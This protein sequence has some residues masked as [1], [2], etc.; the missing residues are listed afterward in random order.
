MGTSFRNAADIDHTE[1]QL[2][3]LKDTIGNIGLSNDASVIP[4]SE[5]EEDHPVPKGVT[6]QQFERLFQM[7]DKR[8]YLDFRVHFSLIQVDI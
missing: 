6:G 8:E 7:H 2:L 5:P 1:R 3:E 4:E